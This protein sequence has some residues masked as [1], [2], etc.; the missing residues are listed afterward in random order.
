MKQNSLEEAIDKNYTFRNIN[1]NMM[2]NDTA[3]EI[4]DKNLTSVRCVNLPRAI[5]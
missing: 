2:N 4:Y 5:V 3:F 1:H